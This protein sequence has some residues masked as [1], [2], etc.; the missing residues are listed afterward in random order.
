MVKKMLITE[1]KP[2]NEKHKLQNATASFYFY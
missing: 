2:V 1:I